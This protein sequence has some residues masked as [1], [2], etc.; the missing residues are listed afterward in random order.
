MATTTN[1][2]DAGL[3]PIGRL[4]RGPFLL[5][6]GLILAFFGGLGVWGGFAPLHS[7]AIAPG[8]IV[9]QTNRKTIQHL[10]GGIVRE[11]LVRDGDV[12]QA[13]DVLIR[14]DDTKARTFLDALQ[15]RYYATLAREAR[16]AAERDGRPDVIFPPELVQAGHPAV[17]DAMAGQRRIFAARRQWLEGQVAIL[18]QQI[19]QSRE[20]ITALRAQVSSETRQAELIAEEI[21][22]V[23]SLVAKGLERKPRLLALQ[24]A[25]EEINGSRGEHLALI[26]RAEQRIGEAELQ[27]SDL[28]N[29][30]IDEI[31]R[32]LRDV[33]S[34]LFELREK[35]LAARDVLERTEIRAPRDG[36][37][38]QLRV[39]TIGGVIGPGEPILDIVPHEDN[40]VLEAR[41]RMEDIDSVRAGLPAQIRLVAYR[42]RWTPTVDG[43]VETVSADRLEDSRT[44]EAFFIARVRI[45]PA[46]LATLPDVSLYP[47]MPAEVLILTGART[48][49]DY[50]IAPITTSLTRAFRED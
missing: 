23:E 40:L 46:S 7:A 31:T 14:L 35:V 1:P 45:D 29:R 38:V 47:G 11:I 8:Q 22:G 43:V 16:L 37:V 49:F 28:E 42:Q 17:A 18:R 27:I 41:V 5:G 20:E 24:R 34:E 26:A 44:G 36:V 48:P 4:V 50:M 10:E 32:E 9:V 13:N 19:A 30:R 39:H 33:Q 15:A 25:A 6:C 3:P 12:V 21:E 2:V